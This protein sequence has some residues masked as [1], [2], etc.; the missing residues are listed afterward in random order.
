MCPLQTWRYN[1]LTAL[2][3][4]LVYYTSILQRN[5]RKINKM[6]C[7]HKNSLRK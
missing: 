5:Y 6:H 4:V 2:V 7:I 3:L 1:I